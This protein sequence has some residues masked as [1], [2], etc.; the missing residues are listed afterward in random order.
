M[1]TT[2]TGFRIVPFI[3]SL[4]LTLSIGG[5]AGFFTVPQIKGW[6]VY[7]HK[8]FFNPPNWI[9]GPVWTALYVMIAVAAYL[10]WTHRGKNVDYSNAVRIYFLQLLFNFLWSIMFFGLHQILGAM[11]IITLLFITIVFNV[12]AFSRISKPAAW[13]LLPYLLWVSFAW[14]L[15]L[16]VY[17]LNK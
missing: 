10:I 3:L 1:N 12:K 6:Y 14:V 15:N 7:L 5:I 17:I 2:K 13:L 9:F 4:L 8:P 11:V 16:S